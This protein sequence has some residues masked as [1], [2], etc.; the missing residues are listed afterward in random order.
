MGERCAQP[1]CSTSKMAFLTSLLQLSAVKR[2]LAIDAL[3]HP[4]FT[5]GGIAARQQAVADRAQH[6][7]LLFRQHRRARARR[8]QLL[9]ARAGAPHGERR[10]AGQRQRCHTA[11]LEKAAP[12]HAPKAIVSL[13]QVA[14]AAQRIVVAVA[15]SWA[16]ARGSVLDARRDRGAAR[17]QLRRQQHQPASRGTL[18][19]ASPEPPDGRTRFSTVIT[20]S[21]SGGC[22][23]HGHRCADAHHRQEASTP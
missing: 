22:D 19:S 13:F 1:P 10:A 20:R 6:R 12:I 14:Q 18:R 15:R 16:A 21:R 5:R 2:Q 7:Q 3:G 17:A 11:Q 4:R 23:H 9:I 8:Q